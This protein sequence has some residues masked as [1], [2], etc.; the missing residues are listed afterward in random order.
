MAASPSRLRRCAICRWNRAL[1]NDGNIGDPLPRRISDRFIPGCSGDLE[2]AFARSAAEIEASASAGRRAAW[3]WISVPGWDCT[4]CRLQSAALRSL[5]WTTARCCWMNCGR[6]ADIWP[7]AVHHADLLEFRRF[8]TGQAQVI[9]CMGDTLTHLPALS[10][11]AIAAGGRGGSAAAAAACSRRPFATTPTAR[12]GRRAAIHFGARR[13]AADLDLLSRI[14]GSQ[15]TVTICC[16]RMQDGRW[17]QTVSSYPETAARAGV[18]DV[19]A[20]RH[21]A[22]A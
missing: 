21:S 2:A 9:V 11:V 13:C 19:Q 5:L 6:A 14:W 18:G 12:I 3:R 15:V 17:R 8:L 20:L 22:S 16:T 10:G 4:P 1:D 7:I